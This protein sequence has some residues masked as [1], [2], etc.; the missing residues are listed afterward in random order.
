MCIQHQVKHM[1]RQLGDIRHIRT[2]LSQ[3][4]INM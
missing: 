2:L 3:R 1:Q 4:R